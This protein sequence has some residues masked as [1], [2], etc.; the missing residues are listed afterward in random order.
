MAIHIGKK[1]KE[2]FYRQGLSASQFAK[3]LNKSRNVIYNIFARESLDTNLLSKIGLILHVDFFS[4]YLEQKEYKKEN[5]GSSLV[6]ELRA[7]YNALLEK[8]NAAEKENAALRNEVG[9]LK[10]IIELLEE[11][12]KKER[13]STDIHTQP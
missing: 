7:A 11:K 10:K 2:E 13:N 5:I 4:P 1:I 12:E 8:F 6:K 9:Q 3:K